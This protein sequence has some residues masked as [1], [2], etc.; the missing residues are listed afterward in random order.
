M[1]CGALSLVVGLVLTRLRKGDARHRLLGWTYVVA[2]SVGLGAILVGTR[3][4]PHPFAGYATLTILVLAAAVGASR[5]R[6]RVRSW[7]AWHGALMSMTLMGAVM[8]ALG[9]LGGAALGVG[10]GLAYYRLFNAVIAVTSLAGLA[11][12]LTRPVIW[13]RAPDAGVRMGYA[14]LVVASSGALIAAQWG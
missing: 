7:R 9:V 1:A 5:L 14:L 3:A 6:Q 12:I 8:A 13:G 4:H 10:N 11:L 2:M